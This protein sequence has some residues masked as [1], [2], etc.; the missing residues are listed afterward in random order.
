MPLFI[1]IKLDL[2]MNNSIRL[3]LITSCLI[4]KGTKERII[5]YESNIIN[6]AK[7]KNID[8]FKIKTHSF[9]FSWEEISR[10][11]NEYIGLVGVQY[12]LNN[13]HIFSNQISTNLF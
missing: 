2:D 13:F 7:P 5:Q 11:K 3:I 10:N 9:K 4:G 1:L 6:S 8:V 12:I